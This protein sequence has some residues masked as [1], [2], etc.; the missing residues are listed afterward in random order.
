MF[1]AV[2]RFYFLLRLA[3]VIIAAAAAFATRR[4]LLLIAGFHFF[5]R[6]LL[7]G[8][9]RFRILLLRLATV[10]T[11]IVAALAAV[12]SGTVITGV[13]AFV[14]IATV[15]LPWLATILLTLRFFFRFRRGCFDGFRFFTA[16]QLFQRVKEA[17]K[18]TRLGRL[19]GGNIILFRRGDANR[20]FD[21]RRRR[22]HIW[23]SECRQRRLFRAFTL[24]VLFFRRQR[25][26]FFVQLRQHVA[27]GRRF[28]PFAY[29]Q[30][31]IVR[32]FHLIVRDDDTADAILTRL[33]SVHCRP[34]FV[35]QIRGDRHRNNGM[36]F[37]RILFQRFFFNQAQNG[38]RQRFVIAHG[39]GTATARTHVMAGFA[40]RRAQALTRHFEQAEAGNMANLNTRP[41]LTHRFTQAVFYRAL[42]TYRR[43][44]DKV[45]NDQ[46]AQVAQTQLA[47][48]LIG[49]FQVGIK[50]RFFD[51]AAAS[52]AGGVDIDGG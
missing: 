40:Q 28:F 30:H 43:H 51:I 7:A 44:I 8:I 33:N 14:T 29:A 18:Q 42:V 38:Q 21:R 9:A 32:R 16:E 24:G 13:A 47:G 17:A 12:T 27:Q 15:V 22:R 1:F 49:R 31:G 37:L 41:V 2:K 35:K 48:N 39:A 23:H 36:D 4:L 25:H 6:F 52:R 10:T 46:A 11:I 19:R 45:D 34:F 20:R 26:R 3:F 50:R 5:R